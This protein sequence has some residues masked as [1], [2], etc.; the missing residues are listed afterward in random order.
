MVW[1]RRTAIDRNFEFLPLTACCHLLPLRCLC[2]CPC[3]CRPGR[4]HGDGDCRSRR[5]SLGAVRH[6]REVETRDGRQGGREVRAATG[7]RRRRRR[8]R[9]GGDRAG[10]EEC[11]D[12][13]CKRR[14]QRLQRLSSSFAASSADC[15]SVCVWRTASAWSASSV[16]RRKVVLSSEYVGPCSRQLR[17]RGGAEQRWRGRRNGTADAA[18]TAA[19]DPDA[20]AAAA[21]AAGAAQ[22]AGAQVRPEAPQEEARVG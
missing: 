15:G 5:G 18:A 2:P 14:V 20:A 10:V 11:R 16:Q 21:A 4:R 3:C 9:E 22:A 13:K 17:R 6:V 19:G 8:R 1:T 12:G 7:Q